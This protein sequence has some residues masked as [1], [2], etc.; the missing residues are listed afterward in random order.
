MV[1]GTSSHCLVKK[2]KAPRKDLR[3]W[4]K[5]VFGNVSFRKLEVFSHVQFW[6]SKERDNPLSIEEVEARK[7]PLEDYKKWV[8][9]EETSWRQK[10][11]EIQLKEGDKNTKFFH[12]MA[13]AHARRN[14]LSKVRINRVT[15]T[16]EEEIKVGVCRAYQTLLTENGD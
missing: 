1:I 15:M 9:L 16:D 11:K 5:E 8:L 6:D 10:S 2:S 12:K 3:V 7:G 13:N 14:L 4:N